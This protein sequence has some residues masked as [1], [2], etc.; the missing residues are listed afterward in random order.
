ME[1]KKRALKQELGRVAD[2]RGSMGGG[3]DVR[4]EKK[5]KSAQLSFDVEDDEEEET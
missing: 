4:K 2:G 3:G 5:A 1:K